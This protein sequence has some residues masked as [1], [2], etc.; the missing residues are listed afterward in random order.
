MPCYELLIIKSGSTDFL[1]FFL[2]IELLKDLRKWW[3][4]TKPLLSLDLMGKLKFLMVEDLHEKKTTKPVIV[5]IFKAINFTVNNIFST[6]KS[7]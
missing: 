4:S 6:E 7:Q 3:F 5:K 1:S 2:I